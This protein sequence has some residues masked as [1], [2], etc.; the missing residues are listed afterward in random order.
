MSGTMSYVTGSHNFKVGGL[1]LQSY[2]DLYQ[3]FEQ[4]I[5]YT[6]AGR[7][8]ESVTYYAA[9]LNAKMRTRQIGLF[10]QEQWTL[11]RLTLYGGLRYDSD[12]G[13]NP[14][15]DV[16]AGPYIGARHYDEGRQRAELEGHQ[17]A[18]RL[19]VRPVRQRPHGD[20]GKPRPLRGF[21]SQ[22]RDRLREQPGQPDRHQRDARLDRQQRLRAAGERARTAVESRTSGAPIQTT[23]YS[24]E[25][26]HGWG[27]RGYNWQAALSLQ[28]ELVTGIGL[29]VG[30]YR[31]W[32]GN[33][34]VTDNTLV[35]PSDYDPYCITA[36]TNPA[37]R[38][39][40]SRSAACSRSNRRSSDR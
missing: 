26:L 12:H 2:R 20:Q 24:D 5:S 10:A 33:F 31:T 15:Q 34:V 3:P 4:A 36:P 8:P 32:Y 28:H 17:S 1:L 29:N 37:C 16:P 25:V 9:P 6:F 39:A 23:V 18:R 11:N 35:S 13:W 27:N 19:R 14:A 22:R 30:Y 38:T 21:R 7:V 40:A